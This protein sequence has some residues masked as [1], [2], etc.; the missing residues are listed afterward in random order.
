MDL[1]ITLEALL[2]GFPFF[3]VAGYLVYRHRKLPLA[4]QLGLND[5]KSISADTPIS[6]IRGKWRLEVQYI[7]N[8]INEDKVRLE[9]IKVWKEGSEEE[10]FEKNEAM[11]LS[12]I[13]K[14]A[15]EN[16]EYS[17]VVRN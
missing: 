2:I 13:I 17:N 10:L 14:N 11:Q 5:Y 3:I 16:I 8:K 4:T 6:D 9:V 1:K 7:K 15:V 12:Q